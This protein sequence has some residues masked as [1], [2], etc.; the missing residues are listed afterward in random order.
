MG[1][2]NRQIKCIDKATVETMVQAAGAIDPHEFDSGHVVQL[3]DSEESLGDSVA[4]FFRDG[5]VGNEHMICVTS[6]ERWYSIAMRLA[7]L[8][9]PA[10]EALRFGR[11][12]VR[13][14]TATL[15]KFMRGG[16]IAPGLFHA[17][18]GTLVAGMSAFGR[19]VRIYGDMVDILASQGEY[20]A[21]LELEHS[22]NELAKRHGFIL[23]C[24]YTAG[25]FGDP[26][27][28]EDLCRICGAHDAVR[29]SPQDVLGSFLVSRYCVA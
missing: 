5:L 27:N 12:V 26:H 24:G 3:F 1:K 13:D 11:L 6:E 22:W 7:A 25:H 8:G 16:T 10:D 19:R 28:S 4:R 23:L 9:Q 14:S 20:A 29:S 21:A 17:T 18:V 2:R 15:G